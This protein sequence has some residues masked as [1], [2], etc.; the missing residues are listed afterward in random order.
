MDFDLQKR[1][2]KINNILLTKGVKTAPIMR[3]GVALDISGSM[4]HIIRTGALQ[5]AF[6]QLMGVS[7]KFDDNGELDV[8]KFDTHCEYVGTSKP[9]KGDYDQY[10]RKNRIEPRG[11]TA[12]A[13]I[14]HETMKFFF[15]HDTGTAPKKSFFGGLFGKSA[16]PAANT[17]DTPVLMMVLTDGEP[18][19]AREAMQALR[20]AENESIYFHMVGIGGTRKNFPTIAKLADDLDNVGEV[21]FPKLHM[22]D[23]EIYDQLICDELIQFVAKHAPTA[24]SA[25]A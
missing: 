22:S 20:A 5:A 24:R 19:D 9:E 4:E 3:V 21:Y 14:V 7:V 13:P 11:G 25:T 18:G 10:I 16:E 12:Y 2:A 15:G 23:E 17:D 1:A 6:D 8:F